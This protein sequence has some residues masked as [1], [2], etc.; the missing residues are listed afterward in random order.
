MTILDVQISIFILNYYFRCPNYN[1]KQNACQINK[2]R[3]WST[4]ENGSGS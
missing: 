3:N 2:N 4:I 1:L